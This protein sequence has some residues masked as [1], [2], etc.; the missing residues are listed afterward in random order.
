MSRI[1]D[2]FI[3]VYEV[4]SSRDLHGNEIKV[5][6]YIHDRNRL[7][8]YVRELSEKEKFMAKSN[9][10]EQSTIMQVNYNK[11]IVAGLYV[12]FNNCTYLIVS[13][14]GFEFYKRDLT[15]RLLRVKT[16][17]IESEEF[18]GDYS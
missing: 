9:S 4:K 2:K 14:D 13:V 7:R 8:A 16:E 6:K 11:K 10:S 3:S 17:L 18:E 1:K 5:K 12:N 15:L